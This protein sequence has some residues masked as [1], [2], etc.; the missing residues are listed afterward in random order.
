MK[1]EQ[2]K[3]KIF[4]GNMSKVTDPNSA[5]GNLGTLQRGQILKIYQN[6]ELIYSKNNYFVKPAIK[7]TKN[8]KAVMVSH[9]MQETVA[10][11]KVS[12]INNIKVAKQRLH[13]NNRNNFDGPEVFMVSKEVEGLIQKRTGKEYQYQY[14]LGMAQ[15]AGESDW[16]PANIGND[17]DGNLAVIDI[18]GPSI[19]SGDYIGS[20]L[21]WKDFLLNTARV[22]FKNDQDKLYELKQLLWLSGASK[23][24]YLKERRAFFVQ[25][26]KMSYKTFDNFMTETIRD[27]F[28]FISTLSFT[29]NDLLKKVAKNR[30]KLEEESFS[31]FQDRSKNILKCCNK[32]LKETGKDSDLYKQIT[33]YIDGATEFYYHAPHAV[34]KEKHI[35]GGNLE[36]LQQELK[37]IRDIAF[38]DFRDLIFSFNNLDLTEYFNKKQSTMK[39]KTNNELKFAQQVQ[40]QE[41]QE[42]KTTKDMV[43]KDFND[44]DFG[45]NNVYFAEFF[46]K[47]QA[48]IEQETNSELKFA[49]Q[50]EP[51]KQIIENIILLLYRGQLAS[52]PLAHLCRL[53]GD[54]DVNLGRYKT[55]SDIIEKYSNIEK[56]SKDEN[57]ELRFAESKFVL[58]NCINSLS[59]ISQS[60]IGEVS[61]ITQHICDAIKHYHSQKSEVDADEKA[62]LESS[63]KEFSNFINSLNN[64]ALKYFFNSQ[65]NTINNDDE[66][67]AIDDENYAIPKLPEVNEAKK[68]TRILR[69]IISKEDKINEPQPTNYNNVRKPE[70]SDVKPRKTVSL[71][72]LLPKDKQTLNGKLIV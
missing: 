52:D 58:E 59:S 70:S 42:C 24:D 29:N 28:N 17:K 41:Y 50:A 72:Q 18:G 25:Q 37:E 12:H 35:L 67:Y 3:Y 47:T 26:S 8:Q 6:S 43:Y 34:I 66:D 45:C 53:D 27:A 2:S 11:S 38:K 48:T 60:N 62:K 68:I 44:L 15:I 46:N 20:Y 63:F 31:A 64:E 10:N 32:A 9:Q 36:R 23:G 30:P 4:T 54:H 56:Y 57:C 40:P 1:A 5:S 65:N 14:Y 71:Q 55:L 39:Q 33:A 13:Y 21:F 7:E 16:N 49:K 51:F 19:K 69:K 22:E 61:G